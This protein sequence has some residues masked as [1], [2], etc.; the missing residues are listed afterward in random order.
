MTA[1]ITRLLIANRGEI[2]RRIMRTAHARGIVCVAV[3]SEPDADEIFVAEADLAVALAG[4]SSAQTY[5]D[6]EQLLAAARITDCDAIH[7]GY[8]FLSE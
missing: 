2:A 8:G 5:L 6:R 1:T 7:P 3:F 4:V